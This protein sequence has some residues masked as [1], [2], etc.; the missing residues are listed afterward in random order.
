MD[1]HHSGYHQAA[2]PPQTPRLFLKLYG[3]FTHVLQYLYDFPPDPCH[4]LEESFTRAVR[5][6]IALESPRRMRA[7]QPYGVTSA[8]EEPGREP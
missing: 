1:G 5:P 3:I 6:G 8:A 2:T 4:T 7:L